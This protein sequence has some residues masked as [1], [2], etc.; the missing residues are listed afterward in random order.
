[1]S[2]LPVIDNCFRI[3]VNFQ[4][5][6]GLTPRCIHHIVTATADVEEVGDMWWD[7]TTEGLYGPMIG[8]HE[9]LSI[10]VLPLDGIH[11]TVIVDNPGITPSLCLGS[12][13]SMPAV[14]ALV[15]LRTS[16]RGPRGRGRQYVGPLVEQAQ[17]QGIME[18]ATRANLQDAW[19]EFQVN[20]LAQDPVCSLVV[21]S[22][23]H[24]EAVN[25]QHI[26]VDQLV[27]T[28]RR[29]QDQLR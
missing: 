7:S 22:Y 24:Q 5:V 19:N 6:S 4:T 15:S 29:R 21:A 9:P 18:G 17:D 10:D 2:P 1:M 26:T 25:V 27:A 12:G 16:I 14:A 11:A 13:Q 28:Q 20:L 23:V 8:D 3:A